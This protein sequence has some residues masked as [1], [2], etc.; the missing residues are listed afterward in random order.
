[1]R[2]DE[3]SIRK[4]LEAMGVSLIKQNEIIEKLMGPTIKHAQWGEQLAAVQRELDTNALWETYSGV[5]KIAPEGAPYRI[6][7]DNLLSLIEMDSLP[8]RRGNREKSSYR[9]TDFTN[10][11]GRHYREDS[12]EISMLEGK[13]TERKIEGLKKKKRELDPPSSHKEWKLIF[14]DPPGEKPKSFIISA[15]TIDDKPIWGAPDLVFKHKDTGE[16]VIIERKSTTREIPSDGWPDLRAQLWT[17][18]HI[19]EFVDA[20]KISLVGEVWWVNMGIPLIKRT[21]RWDRKD[22]VFNI[23]NRELFKLFGG[24]IAST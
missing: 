23:Q 16:I 12:N 7:H 22:A 5:Q 14:R 8:K 24:V 11:I 18:G 2:F 19:D 1:V 9:V 3:E 13:R 20:K 4:A 10:W 15:L 6:T 21:L 17:Y